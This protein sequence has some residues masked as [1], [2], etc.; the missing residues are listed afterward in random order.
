MKPELAN[1]TKIMKTSASIRLALF[2]GIALLT[3]DMLAQN[4]Q[5]VD[6]FQYLGY[7]SANQGLAVAPNGVVFAVGVG[8]VGWQALVMASSD[9]GA[10]W[11]APLDVLGGNGSRARYDAG[12]VSDSSG[13]LYAAGISTDILAV[14]WERVFEI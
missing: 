1:R 7:G 3:N 10:T 6:D 9:N 11:S 2:G 13:N 8:G 12:I 5:T 14:I 4:W